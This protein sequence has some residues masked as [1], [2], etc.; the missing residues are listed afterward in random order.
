M[1]YV[2]TVVTNFHSI[3]VRKLLLSLYVKLWEIET[4][5]ITDRSKIGKVWVKKRA[6][7]PLP[8]VQ[9]RRVLE[10][11]WSSKGAIELFWGLIWHIVYLRRS[12]IT[13]DIIKKQENEFFQKV[14]I[15]TI[16]QK[17]CLNIHFLEK[18]NYFIFIISQ[19]IFALQRSI[20]PQINP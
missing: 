17:K 4:Y 8:L 1:S 18:I 2:L 5:A 14:E 16:W 15:C 7:I 20:I 6:H 9:K 19:V 3:Y 12:N 10:Q 13:W 11:K